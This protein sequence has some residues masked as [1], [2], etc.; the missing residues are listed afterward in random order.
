MGFA[1]GV[2]HTAALHGTTPAPKKIETYSSACRQIANDGGFDVDFAFH[3]FGLFA[4]T[5]V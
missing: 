4:E 2:E 5:V 3:R 1:R